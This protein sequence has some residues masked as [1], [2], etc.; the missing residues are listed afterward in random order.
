M[1]GN[2]IERDLKNCT[3]KQYNRPILREIISE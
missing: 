3:K 1:K 2:E